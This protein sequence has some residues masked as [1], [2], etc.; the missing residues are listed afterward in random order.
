VELP[1]SGLLGPGGAVVQAFVVG[2]WDVADL[3]VPTARVVLMRVIL[4]RTSS[5]GVV[6]E[7]VE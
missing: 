2:G 6:L 4:S 7:A 5:G 3:A 1:V